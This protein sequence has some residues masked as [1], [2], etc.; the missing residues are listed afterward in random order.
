M[1]T[2]KKT[3]MITRGIKKISE[4]AAKRRMFRVWNS[5]SEMRRRAPHHEFCPRV[6]KNKG[7]IKLSVFV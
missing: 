3:R 6:C 4:K 7:F 1:N 5:T 2:Y